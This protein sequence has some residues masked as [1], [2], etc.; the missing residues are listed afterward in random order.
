MRLLK[1]QGIVRGRNSHR[2]SFP[3]T[4][5]TGKTMERLTGFMRAIDTMTN[6]L[7]KLFSFLLIPLMCITAIEVVSRYIFNRPTIWAWDV[8]IQLF[9]AIILIGGSYAYLHN[10][11]VRVDLLVIYMPARARACLNLL[12]SMLFFFSYSVLLWQGSLE[13]WQSIKI[14]EQYTSVWS[15]PIYFE[16]MLIPMA[17]SLFLLQGAVQ[18]IRDLLLVMYP[19]M[20][21]K[22]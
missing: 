2:S 13:A 9:G 11:H 21:E 4:T 10:M 15:P 19:G 14:R 3:F 16:K 20:G 17:I 1:Y 5:W 6:F 8:N 7:G 22:K 12:T 18:F